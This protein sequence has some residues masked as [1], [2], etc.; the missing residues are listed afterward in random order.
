MAGRRNERFDTTLAVRLEHGIGV[1]RNV[2]A[3]GI[4]FVTDVALEAGTPVRFTLEFGGLP[5]GPI[6]VNCIARIVRVDGGGTTKGVAA[7]ISSFQFRR[8]ARLSE[9]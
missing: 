6:A 7:E 1:V 9:S 2:S 4:Y 5:S 3:S 8:I